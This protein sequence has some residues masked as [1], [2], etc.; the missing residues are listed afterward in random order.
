MQCRHVQD[1]GRIILRWPVRFALRRLAFCRLGDMPAA[2]RS[3]A[4]SILPPPERAADL[5]QQPGATSGRSDQHAVASRS[6]CPEEAAKVGKEA[7]SRC[8]ADLGNRPRAQG[9]LGARRSGVR[10]H[11]HGEDGA[12]GRNSQDVEK[13]GEPDRDRRESQC[14]GSPSEGRRRVPRRA[15][16]SGPPTRGG[17]ARAQDDA[18]RE[19]AG[20]EQAGPKARARRRQAARLGEEP[21]VHCPA[22][23]LHARVDEK[24]ATCSQT[25][26]HRRRC[27]PW[28]RP[29][30]SRAAHR[31]ARSHGWR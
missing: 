22:V 29:G 14:A 30:T 5:V 23:R 4:V 8:G 1:G 15:S 6:N 24:I 10:A 11:Q 21:K 31:H 25:S 3:A 9:L 17:E 12:Q 16:R 27:R 20:P 7:A 13:T 2:E 19:Q 28:H 18:A 26:G